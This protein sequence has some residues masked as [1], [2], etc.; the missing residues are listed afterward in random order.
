MHRHSIFT[1]VISALIIMNAAANGQ[2][3]VAF[4]GVTV[5]PMD[6]ERVLEDYTIIVEG[7]TIAAMGP[8]ENTPP[9]E[10]ARIIEGGGR[11][12]MPGL[13]EMHGHVSATRPD[14]EDTL[15][16]FVARGVTTVRG[17]LG[18]EGQIA[19]REKVRAGAL[20]GPTLYLA[21]PAI[22]G[23]NAKTPEEARA[24]V[25]QYK[26][27]GWDLLKVHEGLSLPVYEA[28]A[29]EA[30]RV[31]IDFAG[32]VADAVGLE[33]AIR[34]GQRTIEHLDNYLEFMGA[35]ETPATPDRL[36]R[37]VELTVTAGAGVAPTMALWEYFA[38]PPDSADALPEAKY[39]S[40]ETRLSW[41]NRAQSI[42]ESATEESV[43]TA[44]LITENRR[45]LL[46]ALSA[47][48]AEILLASDAPQFFS[49]PGFSTHREMQ[50]MA[51][52]GMRP[53]DILYTGT[54]AA[55]RYFSDPATFGIIAPGMR[56][57]LILL[58]ANPLN[59]IANTTAISGVML[60]G[61][62]LP[63]DEIDTRLAEI[64]AKYGQATE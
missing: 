13:A 21:A 11:H 29:H 56:A 28:L 63:K 15:F 59:D 64:A 8:R 43:A 34:L 33:R 1:S 39:Q 49:V 53:Y 32:H 58:E 38:A 54:T 60:R 51:K 19:M 40:P 37:A 9:P 23:G 31:K 18:G 50:S 12:L 47:G 42:K 6:Q 10:T 27:E 26:Q 46:N 48:G 36:G 2:E 44:S 52:A 35:E 55:G 4:V 20:I 14:A 25:R 57:D 22:H 41:Q 5:I 45:R 30:S 62:W 17:M 16:L 24:K 3:I 61:R 7:E